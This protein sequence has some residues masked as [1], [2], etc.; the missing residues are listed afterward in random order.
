MQISPTCTNTQTQII[1]DQRR[2]KTLETT[3]SARKN[4]REYSAKKWWLRYMMSDQMDRKM[5]RMKAVM[6]TPTAYLLCKYSGYDDTHSGYD[7]THTVGM[8]THTQW[9]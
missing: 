9:V 5:A 1:T 2:K 4:R 7:D 3:V 8:M 6:P